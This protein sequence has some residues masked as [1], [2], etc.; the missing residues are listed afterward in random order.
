MALIHSLPGQLWPNRRYVTLDP[1]LSSRLPKLVRILPEQYVAVGH[2]AR[3][4]ASLGLHREPTCQLRDSKD[5]GLREL[6]WT[7]Y[8]LEKTVSLWQG[9]PSCLNMQSEIDTALPQA[10]DVSI[11]RRA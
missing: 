5:E 10:G 2:A 11:P 7:T 8:I 6:F 1:P 3:L 9:R 4:T